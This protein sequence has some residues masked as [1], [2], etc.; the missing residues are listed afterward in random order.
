M[1]QDYEEL[2]QQLWALVAAMDGRLVGGAEAVAAK[3][4]AQ[5]KAAGF[6]YSPAV[7]AELTTYL[8]SLDTLLRQN[9]AAAIPL[10]SPAPL[11]DKLI[12]S[13][14]EQAFQERWPDGLRLSD[15]LWKFR[16]DTQ[17]GFA[18]VLQEGVRLGQSASGIIY[19]LQRQVEARGTRFEIVH[20]EAEDWAAKLADAGRS[21]IRNPASRDSW[22]RAV[23]EVRRHINQLSDN[24]TRQAA[25]TAFKKM[26]AAVAAGDEALIRETLKWW[27]YDKQL[28]YFKRIARTEVATAQHRAVI[29]SA[30]DDPDV[31]GYLWSV[32]SSHPRF[33][34]CDYYASIDMGL[35]RGVW[36]KHA[37]PKH[38]AHPHCMC[39]L[40]PRVTKIKQRGEV[41]Y[42]D[43]IR[44]I[45]A[46][47]RDKLL[48][49]WARQA[50]QR[51]L[52][53]ES[54]IRP[55]G[56]GLITRDEARARFGAVVA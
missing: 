51:G 37:V 5:A 52:D 13:L 15:R 16:G 23:K 31:I 46:D 34:I 41:N 27:L 29:A 26:R 6:A 39:A 33:D 11:G 10:G 22:Q 32:S 50:Q 35:G 55:D 30:I 9:I 54:L 12:T 14:S 43:F 53:W 45:N 44:G 49:A 25:E 7:Q 38:K 48:P 40:S 17:R 8:D 56:F 4:F 19:D 42:A 20:A 2:H 21:A 28:A 18:Q 24:G 1:E 3:L 47:Q 36:P